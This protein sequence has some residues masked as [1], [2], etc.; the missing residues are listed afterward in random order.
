MKSRYYYSAMDPNEPD[1][2]RT[3][4]QKT[5]TLFEEAK[6]TTT[7]GEIAKHSGLPDAWL[8]KLP[9]INDPSVNRIQKLYET[10]SQRSLRC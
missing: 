10:L 1:N 6:K 3:L 2:H 4:L 5:L 7:V 8:R 9:S